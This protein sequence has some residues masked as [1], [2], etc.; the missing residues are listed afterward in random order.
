MMQQNEIIKII[1]EFIINHCP[2]ELK[3]EITESLPL[4]EVGV[5]D[6]LTSM[7]LVDFLEKQFSITFKAI[8]MDPE[9]FSS[10]EVIARFVESKMKNRG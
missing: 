5:L 9:N 7:E 4:I 1:K 8:D 6:S 2:P 3:S 10:I